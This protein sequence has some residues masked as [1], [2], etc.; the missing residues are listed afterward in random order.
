[1]LDVA[2][3]LLDGGPS[4]PDK[5]WGWRPIEFEQ[6]SEG[7]GWSGS[8]QVSTFRR[9]PGVPEIPGCLVVRLSPDRLQGGPALCTISTHEGPGK[10]TDGR[11]GFARVTY[12]ASS[13]QAEHEAS[14]FAGPIRAWCC[15]GYQP[16]L[17]CVFFGFSHIAGPGVPGCT[18]VLFTFCFFIIHAG[19][20][21]V[22]LKISD[23]Q[24]VI[25]AVIAPTC[26]DNLGM[27]GS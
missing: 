8:G 23:S 21:A 15:W 16:G 18:C 3:L 4:C 24:R 17:F 26:A 9:S 7:L 5:F 13:R 6:G 10:F 22:W 25:I 12:V 1:M 11:E 14:P 20:M 19:R 27:T 2:T